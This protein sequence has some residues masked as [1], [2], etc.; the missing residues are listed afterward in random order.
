MNVIE[1]FNEFCNLMVSELL[2]IN[3]N[4]NDNGEELFIK[5]VTINFVIILL[6]GV[7]LLVITFKMGVHARQKCKAR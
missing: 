6:F 3:S 1:I 5:G 7:N 4:Y 2:M